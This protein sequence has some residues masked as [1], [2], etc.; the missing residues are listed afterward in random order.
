VE[1]GG[2]HGRRLPAASSSTEP[3]I[4]MSR[5]RETNDFVGACASAAPKA[6]Q[7]GDCNAE[8]SVAGLHRLGANLGIG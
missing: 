7:R 2:V 5:S 8:G 6:S 4:D 3:D 1:L